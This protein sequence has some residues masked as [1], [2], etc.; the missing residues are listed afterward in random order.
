MC[1]KYEDLPCSSCFKLPLVDVCSNISCSSFSSADRFL[2]SSIILLGSLVI[3]RIKLF[4][5]VRSAISF[6]RDAKTWRSYCSCLRK[7]VSSCLEVVMIDDHPVVPRTPQNGDVLRL[8][9]RIFQNIPNFAPS[10]LGYQGADQSRSE[11]SNPIRL[12]LKYKQA[13]STCTFSIITGPG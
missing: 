4:D 1:A 10:L 7:F 8:I 3:Q 2:S 13:L 9:F 5:I 6:A 11:C 12:N